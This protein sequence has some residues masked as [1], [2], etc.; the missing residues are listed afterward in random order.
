[1]TLKVKV[2]EAVEIPSEM[3]NVRSAEP[4][5]AATGVTVPIQFGQVPLQATPST[6]ETRSGLLDE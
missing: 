1:M 4:L 2:F 3:V 6:G 5:A